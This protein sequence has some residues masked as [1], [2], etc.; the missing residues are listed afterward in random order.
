[1]RST[2]WHIPGLCPRNRQWLT[3]QH[4]PAFPGSADFLAFPEVVCLTDQPMS[5][6]SATWPL[7][8]QKCRAMRERQQSRTAP[9]HS[10]LVAKVRFGPAATDRPAHSEFHRL[11]DGEVHLRVRRR[12]SAP[13]YPSSC[14]RAGVAPRGGCQFCDISAP[15]WSAA[16][17]GCRKRLARDRPRWRSPA[18]G[19]CIALSRYAEGR[20]SAPVRDAPTRSSAGPRAKSRWLF[21][22]PR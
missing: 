16:W 7:P 13:D 18:R 10:C 9:Q 8:R 5:A 2:F 17:S 12:G 15:P 21:A 14:G 6:S 22:S 1:M 11:R 4:P 3:R 20:E 19:G